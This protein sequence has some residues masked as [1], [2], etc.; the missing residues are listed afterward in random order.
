[1][2]IKEKLMQDLKA[3]M[4]SHDK[5]K[6]D[7]ITMVRAA[8]KQIEV[9]KRVDL[10]DEEVIDIISKQYKERVSSIDEFK[11]GGRDDLVAQTEEEIKIILEYLPKQL[12]DE[13]LEDII[14]EAIEKLSITSK[15]QIGELMKEVMPKVKGKADGKK[16]NSIASKYLN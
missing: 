8:I 11:R 16:V 1:M 12:T 2:S 9:D 14:K 15:K 6:K 10:S 13:E 5:I 7:T 4:K 3:A